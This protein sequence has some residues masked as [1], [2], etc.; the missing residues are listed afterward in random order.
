M[1]PDLGM[2]YEGRGILVSPDYYV[3]LFYCLYV[4]VKTSLMYFTDAQQY[5]DEIGAIFLETSALTA[6]GVNQLF[7]DISELYKLCLP[8]LCTGKYVI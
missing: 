5:C 3:M 7:T 4:L 1:C 2:D 8:Y 6:A